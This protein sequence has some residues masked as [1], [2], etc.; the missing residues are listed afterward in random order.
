MTRFL[1]FI[2]PALSVGFLVTGY[3]LIGIRWPVVGL[4]VLGSFWIIGLVLRWEWVSSLGLF[5]VFGAATFGVFLDLSTELLLSAAIFALMA[6]DLAEFKILLRKA[7][8]EDDIAGL[9]RSHLLRLT[10]VC[11]TGGILA[12]IAL[13][14]HFKLSFEL[15]VIL[16]LISIWGVGRMVN[17]LLSK[18]F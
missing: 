1:R 9:E 14:L 2:F 10:E 18:E 5:L 15:V 17:W 8:T 7:S 13:R 16:M 11:L 6:W 12:A 3:F 4:I